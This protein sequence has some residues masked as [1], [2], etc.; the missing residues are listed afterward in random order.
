MASAKPKDI[1]DFWDK[2]AI[3]KAASSEAFHRFATGAQV[4]A[5][6]RAWG[7]AFFEAFQK[8]K[9]E[10]MK[11]YNLKNEQELEDW[12]KKYNAPLH[13]YLKSYA[14]ARLGV[15]FGVRYKTPPAAPPVWK[16]HWEL[17]K[18]EEMMEKGIIKGAKKARKRIKK[19]KKKP[20]TGEARARRRRKP[21]VGKP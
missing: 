8:G 2:E 3:E 15:G 12:Y 20:D 18:E 11:R 1:E 21:D 13:S 17:T 10:I 16:E 4:A 5:A 6:G 9:D 14:A 7:R 19:E